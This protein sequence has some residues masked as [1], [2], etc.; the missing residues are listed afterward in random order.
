MI[1]LQ[2]VSTSL[3][4]LDG[5]CVTLTNLVKRFIIG[6]K[7]DNIDAILKGDPRGHYKGEP[8]P[9]APRKH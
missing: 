2:T 4:V 8:G 6:E 9:G 1:L 7:A 3:D 5:T